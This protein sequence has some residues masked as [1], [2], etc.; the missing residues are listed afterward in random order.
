[1]SSSPCCVSVTLLSSVALISRYNGRFATIAPKFPLRSGHPAACTG[2]YTA[3]RHAV[4]ARTARLLPAKVKPVARFVFK[5]D[6]NGRIARNFVG[7][8]GSVR[9]AVGVGADFALA[10]LHVAQQATVAIKQ[11]VAQK[12]R[13]NDHQ[14]RHQSHPHEG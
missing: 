2:H 9:V 4:I 10:H 8:G 7:N 12:E 3:E 13:G 6:G 5:V 1:M 11:A 14:Q